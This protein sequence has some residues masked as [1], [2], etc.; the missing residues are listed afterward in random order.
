[1]PFL[2]NHVDYSSDSLTFSDNMSISPLPLVTYQARHTPTLDLEYAEKVSPPILFGTTEHVQPIYLQPLKLKD[3]EILDEDKSILPS[4]GEH[5]I[6]Q[7]GKQLIKELNTTTEETPEVLADV[8]SDVTN[9]AN[10]NDSFF[11]HSSEWDEDHDMSTRHYGPHLQPLP[12]K[13]TTCTLLQPQIS[14]PHPG[15]GW[16]VNIYRTTHYYQFLIPDPTTRRSI[17][18]P[19]LSYSINRSK[20]EVSV[21][22]IVT[23]DQQGL[24][25]PEASFA[26]IINH[27]IN[28]NFSYDLAAA[29]C[30]YQYCRETQYAIQASI[31][32]L[33]EKE[34][35]YLEHAIVTDFFRLDFNIKF[36]LS[37]DASTA[38]MLL[39]LAVKSQAPSFEFQVAVTPIQATELVR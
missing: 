23:I 16:V 32:H 24:L 3:D 29:V 7:L 5:L 31:K 2:V 20:P 19:Y 21:T 14:G 12:S 9:N 18:A 22:Y 25:D 15:Q 35:R 34:M 17:I 13:E 28:N 6:H 33:H 8:P 4:S 39:A 36:P 10:D 37:L 38:A 30:Q 26:D 1:M 11:T 27:V